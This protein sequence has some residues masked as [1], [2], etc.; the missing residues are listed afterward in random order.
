M[1]DNRKVIVLRELTKV[2]EEVVSGSAEELL[3]YFETHKEKQKGEF[4]IIVESS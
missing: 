4:V 2:Y 1:D 3:E